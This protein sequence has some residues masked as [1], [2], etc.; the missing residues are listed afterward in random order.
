MGYDTWISG[1][2]TVIKDIT[3][4]DAQASEALDYFTNKKTAAAGT[5]LNVEE[6]FRSQDE[7]LPRLVGFVTGELHGQGDD[8]E[9]M[10]EVVFY[11]HGFKIIGAEIT[12]PRLEALQLCMDGES[13]G[14]C[15]HQAACS[16]GREAPGFDARP[17]KAGRAGTVAAQAGRTTA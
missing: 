15:V 12:Y 1:T 14:K 6:S 3:E 10:W 9:D 13:C 5:E 8:S 4:K 7:E 17:P 16:L 2:L 11:P